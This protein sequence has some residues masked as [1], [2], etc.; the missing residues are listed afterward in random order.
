M[1]EYILFG[2]ASSAESGNGFKFRHRPNEKRRK[3]PKTIFGWL[4]FDL[5]SLESIFFFSHTI[6]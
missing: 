3:K 5:L 2:S 6:I 1:H 4:Y